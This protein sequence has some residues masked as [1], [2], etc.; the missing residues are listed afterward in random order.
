MLRDPIRDVRVTSD[1]ALR[2]SGAAVLVGSDF[3][4]VAGETRAGLAAFAMPSGELLPW[5]PKAQVSRLS[6]AISDIAMHGGE[7]YIAGYFGRIGGKIRPCLA[8]VDAKT[9]A[10]TSWAPPLVMQGC[11][12]LANTRIAVGGATLVAESYG[13]IDLLSLAR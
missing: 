2:A 10:A 3:E 4:T 9:G 6:P 12:F 11:T 1:W 7:V 5:N 13:R 8:A